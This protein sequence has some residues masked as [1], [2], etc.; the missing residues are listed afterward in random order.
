MSGFTWRA[1]GPG[2]KVA[3]RKENF[4]RVKKKKKESSLARTK[5]LCDKTARRFDGIAVNA[6][7]CGTVERGLSCKSSVLSASARYSYGNLITSMRLKMSFDEKLIARVTRCV[8]SEFSLII[9]L[10]ND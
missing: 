5:I 4:Y 10:N 1:P 8:K 3:F 7:N 6:R 2:S 9:I